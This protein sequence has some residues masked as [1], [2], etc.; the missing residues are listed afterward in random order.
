M[1]KFLGI[2]LLFGIIIYALMEQ[3]KEVPNPYILIA[4]LAIFLIGFYQI[5]KKVPSKEEEND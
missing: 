4:G 5:Y 2:V 3:T 1:K